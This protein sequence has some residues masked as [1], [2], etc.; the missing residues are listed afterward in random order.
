MLTVHDL[1]VAFGPTTAVRDLTLHAGT[2]TVTG[3]LGANGAG[4]TTTLLGIHHRVPRRTGRITLDDQDVTAYDTTALVRAGIALCPENR[5]LFPN[6]TIEDNLL[7]GAYGQGRVTCR[8]RLERIYGR[9]PWLH[10][11][12]DEAAGR[13][14]GGQQQ[15]VAIARALMSEP[16]LILLDE[17]SSGL[18]PVAVDEV[19]QVLH[20]IAAEGTT[21][22][23]VE[24]NVRLVETLC[25]TAYVLAHGRI[26][27][28]GPVAELLG[29]DTVSDAYLGT[30]G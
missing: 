8:R 17:P 16:R 26:T 11:R 15:T 12:R 28:H 7:L 19:G 5:R 21:M 10:G 18:S 25:T 6:L 14:S 20:D 13:L 24:Q 29:T 23:L 27:A 22:L 4:K 9:F 1:T 2:G 3:I 30:A